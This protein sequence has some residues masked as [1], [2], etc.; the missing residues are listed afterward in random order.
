MASAMLSTSIVLPA[1]SLAGS[2]VSS[3]G[4]QLRAVGLPQ[5]MARRQAGVQSRSGFSVRAAEK[6]N[7]PLVRIYRPFSTLLVVLSCNLL[8]RVT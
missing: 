7:A 1:A 4:H 8:V 5:L 3:C 6:D 2:N